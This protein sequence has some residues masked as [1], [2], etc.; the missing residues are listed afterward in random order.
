MKKKREEIHKLLPQTHSPGVDYSLFIM[1]MVLESLEKAEERP[2]AILAAVPPPILT[3]FLAVFFSGGFLSPPIA[4]R[5]REY[6][7]RHF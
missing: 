3:L 1:V 4:W 7:Y 6:L 2:E 5:P